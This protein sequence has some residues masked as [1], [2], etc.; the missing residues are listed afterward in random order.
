MAGQGS[1]SLP[2]NTQG[3][4]RMMLLSAF[5]FEKGEVL[6][7]YRDG[8][9]VLLQADGASV[10]L[11]QKDGSRLRFVAR[12]APGAVFEKLVLLSRLRNSCCHYNHNGNGGFR[13]LVFARSS[14]SE[15]PAT[16][17]PVPYTH[18]RWTKSPEHATIEELSDGGIIL[19]SDDSKTI[20]ALL[21]GHKWFAVQWPVLVQKVLDPKKSNSNRCGKIVLAHKYIHKHSMELYPVEFCPPIWMHPLGLIQQFLARKKEE[22][23]PPHHAPPSCSSGSSRPLP[24]YDAAA[25]AAAGGGGGGEGAATTPL[26][27]LDVSR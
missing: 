20:V 12:Y 9:S 19:T 17:E 16:E 23:K 21:P 11:Y 2:R 27:F 3:T 6:G 15:A 18:V 24:N 7:R 14:V 13:P 1:H 26:N 10:V 22:A 8:S 5:V 25:A 4:R